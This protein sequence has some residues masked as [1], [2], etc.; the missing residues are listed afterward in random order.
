MRIM[1]FT[2]RNSFLLALAALCFAPL[3]AAYTFEYVFHKI[4]CH[5]CL[6]E[7][8]PYI[9]GFIA[10]LAGAFISKKQIQDGILMAI[11]LGFLAGLG[12]TLYHMGVEYRLINLPESCTATLGA[13][14]SFEAMKLALLKA[15][16][17]RCDIPAVVIFGLSLTAYNGLYILGLFLLGALY[18]KERKP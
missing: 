8:Y 17:V 4:P 16:I 13:E 2:S 1:P 15:P 11:Y 6:Y 14:G 5:L 12:V 10:G 9:F 3:V 18:L 7:R